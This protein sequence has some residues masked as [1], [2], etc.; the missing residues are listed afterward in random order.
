MLWVMRLRIPH[1]PLLDLLQQKTGFDRGIL[2]CSGSDSVELRSKNAR[3]ATG[4]KKILAFDRS[5]HGLAFGSLPTTN[6]KSEAFQQPFS[7]W[8]GDHVGYVERGKLPPKSL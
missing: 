6:Y 3:I 2:G 5:Y 4:R 8:L 7:S 1:N